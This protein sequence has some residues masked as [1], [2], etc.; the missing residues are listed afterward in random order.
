MGVMMRRPWNDPM[1]VRPEGSKSRVKATSV[2][3]MPDYACELPLWNAAWWDLS[4]SNSLLNDLAD[5]Q[6]AFDA[7]FQEVEGWRT[8]QAAEAWGADAAILVARLRDELGGRL[9]LEVDL[10]PL[11]A[12]G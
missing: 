8:V 12:A 2:K 5:W 10:W 4:L 3:L 1:W 11:E 7:G 6:E 9:G